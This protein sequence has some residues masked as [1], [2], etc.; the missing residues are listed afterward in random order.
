MSDRWRLTRGQIGSCSLLALALGFGLLAGGCAGRDNDVTGSI[1]PNAAGT[2]DSNV[3]RRVE[4]LA[5]R[6]RR[7]P[8][9]PQIAIDYAQALRATGQRDQA[10]AVL[11][12]ATILHPKDLTITGAYGRALA[13]AGNYEQALD[14]LSRAHSP[15]QPNWRIY[16]VQGAVLDQMGRHQEA[17]AAYERALTINPDDPMVLSNLGLSAALSKDL[18][19]AEEVLRKAVAHPRA[20]GRVRQNLA[21]VVGLQGRF[22]EAERLVSADLPQRR[23]SARDAGPAEHLEAD[24][25]TRQARRLRQGGDI[26]APADDADR[27]AAR[28]RA[29]AQRASDRMKSALGLFS[30]NW[31]S[32]CRP[33]P[34]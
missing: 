4:E 28:R 21:L 20:D 10:A 22:E 14:V 33:G 6:Y 9:N 2:S 32:G 8:A 18:T 30:A 5:E 29:I 31:R 27:T 23:L 1:A 24:R 19:R 26:A 17:R 12:R 7:E 13:D 15:D 34:G 16:N 25:Q 3:R 11:Q